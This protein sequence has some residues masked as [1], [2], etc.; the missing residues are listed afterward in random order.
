[1]F[2]ANLLKFNW[3]M[4]IIPRKWL[5]FL[6]RSEIL[7]SNNDI[8]LPFERDFFGMRYSG[9][10]NNVIDFHCYFYGAFEKGQLFFWSDIAENLFNNNGVYV[11]I[12]ANVGHHSIFMSKKSSFVH[13]FEPYEPVRKKIIEK[14]NLNKLTNIIIHDVGIGDKDELLTFYEPTGANLGIGTFVEI[15]NSSAPKKEF[16]LPV[17]S[18]DGYFNSKISNEINMIKID[19]EGFE[20]YVITGL[21]KIIN[22]YRPVIVF[23]LGLGLDCSFSSNIEINDSFPSNYVFYIFD[24]WDKFGNKDKRKDGILRKKGI[25]KLNTFN[26]DN[27]K[28]QADIIAFPR[29]QLEKFLKIF[30]DKFC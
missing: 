4:P 16:Q 6:Y 28:E 18:G 10:I 26:F 2:I 30:P 5:R 29:E 22:K 15:E 12:G 13:A 19:V 17:V 27:L 8:S 24:I 25:Y 1:M 23:E 20:K 11:D 3:Y 14:I 21:Y 9:D 7:D